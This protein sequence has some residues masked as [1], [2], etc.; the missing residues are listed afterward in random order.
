MSVNPG[1]GGQKFIN[2][3]IKKIKNL[4]KMIIE[5]NLDVIIEI[6]GGVDTTTITKI[7][8]AGVDYFVAG[9]AV[10]GDANIEH[11]FKEL[12]KYLH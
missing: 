10:F 5:Q 9:N 4:S 7:V 1:F 6:D 2:S 3:S 11:N 8:D 12:S